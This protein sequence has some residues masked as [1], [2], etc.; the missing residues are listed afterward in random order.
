MCK[1]LVGRY[2]CRVVRLLM[3]MCEGRKKIGRFNYFDHD[4]WSAL[5]MRVYW[6]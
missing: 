1:C 4:F 6:M 2:T 5:L 3:C